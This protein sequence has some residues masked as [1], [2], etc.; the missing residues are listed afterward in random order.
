MVQ[1]NE[2]NIRRMSVLCRVKDWITRS[3]NKVYRSDDVVCGGCP[4]ENCCFETIPVFLI[5]SRVSSRALEEGLPFKVRWMLVFNDFIKG[6]AL[7]FH[8]GCLFFVSVG[9][10]IG[11]VIGKEIRGE[12]KERALHSV[13]LGWFTK[14]RTAFLGCW[15]DL[16]G[17]L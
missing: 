2:R 5:F 1:R 13:V 7:I 6:L 9:S 10:R 11:R 4:F 12:W 14:N 8:S 3:V 17:F 16:W 15:L